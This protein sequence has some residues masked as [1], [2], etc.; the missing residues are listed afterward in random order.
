MT[1][2]HAYTGDQMLVDGPHSDLRRARAAAINIVPSSTGAARATGLVLESMQ[3]KLDGTVAPRARPRRLDHRLRRRP[4]HARPPSTRS[5]RPSAAAAESGPLANVLEY[6][7][8]PLVSSDIVG[9]PGVVHVRLPAH[10]GRSATWSR[11]SAGTTTSGATRTAW[12]TS[13]RSSAPPTRHD[14]PRP[15]RS[16]TCRPS[17]ASGSSLRADFNVPLRRRRITDDLRIRAAAAHACSG[18]RSGARPSW[19]ARTSA[20][21]KGTPDPKYSVAPGPGPA[22]RAGARRRAAREPALRPGRGGATTRRSSATLVDGL[23]AY[24]NDAFG[25]VAPGPRLDRRPAADAAVA[26]PA[27][28]WRTRSTCCSACATEPKRPVRGRARRVEGQRQAR[29]HRGAARGGRRAADRRRDVLHVPRRPGPRRRRLP[30]RA[31][32]GRR[33]AGRCSTTT[34]IAWCSPPTS[35]RWAR[36]AS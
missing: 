5:T 22:R 28:C 7:E 2:V 20:G 17:R 19:R 15:D 9:S 29:R 31:G 26:R 27:G 12:S 3:G 16:R 14:G 23:D 21:P 13:C 25:A 24:V 32:P 34:A 10:H 11:C 1:T 33:P 8:E 6:S 30:A 36:A 18:C 4:Q 35:S